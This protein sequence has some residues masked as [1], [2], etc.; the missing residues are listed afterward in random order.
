MSSKDMRRDPRL[1]S[2]DPVRLGWEDA[3]TGPRFVTGKCVDVSA[4]GLKIEMLAPIPVRTYVMIRAEALGLSGSGVVKHSL[5]RG[6]KYIVGV[7]LSERRL[8]K[9]RDVVPQH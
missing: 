1:A 3:S 5:R 4:A 9:N 7:Q 8:T 2:G 6:A